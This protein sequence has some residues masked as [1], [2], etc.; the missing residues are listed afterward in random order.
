MRA[1]S[2]SILLPVLAGLILSGCAVD[3][4]GTTHSISTPLPLRTVTANAD[5]VIDSSTDLVIARVSARL[6]LPALGSVTRGRVVT[7][8]C[9]GACEKLKLEAAAGDVV[10]G[11]PYFEFE[12][13]DM[14]TL[15][16]DPPSGWT[17]ISVSD[18]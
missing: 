13:G 15:V 7:V 9:A 11:A 17:I 8:R 10:E 4:G 14:V 16:A 5:M 3:I 6:V 18:L 2:S 1:A 12:A